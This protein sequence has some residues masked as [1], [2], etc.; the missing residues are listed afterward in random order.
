[1]LNN[2]K[3]GRYYNDNSFVHSL[4]CFTKIIL[5]ILY[6][7]IISFS[8]LLFIILIISILT[9]YY[10][11]LTNVPYKYYFKSVWDIKYLLIFIF[12]LNII[13]KTDIVFIIISILK[14]ILLLLFSLSFIYTS[15]INDMLQ[16]FY[17]ILRPFKFLSKYKTRIVFILTVAIKFIPC[18]IIEYNKKIMSLKS[19]NIYIN[20]LKIKDKIYIYKVLIIS[21]FKSVLKQADNMSDNLIVRNYRYDYENKLTMNLRDYFMIDIFLIVL[22]GVVICAI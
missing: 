4:C 18:V 9:L 3:I 8:N 6:C 2:I 11:K 13:F 5:L 7:I 10:L 12:I 17:C 21:L 16:G 20:K 19:R 22:L 14:I 1:M 15:S